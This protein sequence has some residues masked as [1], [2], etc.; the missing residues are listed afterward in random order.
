MT[1]MSKRIQKRFFKVHLCDFFRKNLVLSAVNTFNEFFQAFFGF[2]QA[3]EISIKLDDADS[4]KVCF[5]SDILYTDRYEI[6]L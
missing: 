6:N 1:Q 4:R 2:G 3:A 5:I